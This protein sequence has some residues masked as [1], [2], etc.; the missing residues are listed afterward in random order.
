MIE[1]LR[2][3]GC[4]VRCEVCCG[5]LRKPVY[6]GWPDFRICLHA[7]IKVCYPQTVI[8]D[9]VTSHALENAAWKRPAGQLIHSGSARSFGA[10]ALPRSLPAIDEMK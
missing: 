8:S 3:S 1:V 2:R 9:A 7:A 5:R 4:D 10:P 6:E